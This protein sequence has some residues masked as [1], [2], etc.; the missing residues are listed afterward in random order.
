MAAE[1]R[2]T[3]QW[4]L[5][6]LVVLSFN[7]LYRSSFYM[8]PAA[9]TARSTAVVV[10]PIAPIELKPEIRAA[11]DKDI[12]SYITQVRRLGSVGKDFQVSPS[13]IASSLDSSSSSSL[14][15]ASPSI[16][17]GFTGIGANQPPSFIVRPSTVLSPTKS[18]VRSKPPSPIEA[19]KA[20]MKK[21]CFQPL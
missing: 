18:F 13:K 3:W 5:V 11:L 4:V 16:S 14:S 21:E 7:A 10:Q 8:A 9:A 2:K 20:K 12:L 6:L 19:V 1:P 15:E 17:T